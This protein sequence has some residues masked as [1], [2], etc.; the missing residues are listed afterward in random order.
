MLIGGVIHH[1]LDDHPNLVVMGRLQEVLEIPQSAITRVDGAI[2]RD[3]VTVVA[4]RRREERH[5][6]DGC[7]AEF[8]QIFQ[9][10]LNTLE[11]ANPVSV[12]IIKGANVDLINYGVFV[13]EGLFLQQTARFPNRA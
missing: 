12:C 3:I 11:V 9:F 10:L 13:P 4:K 6:P 8:L 1:H 5:K 7:D 2:V